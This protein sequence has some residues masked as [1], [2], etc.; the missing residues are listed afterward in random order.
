MDRLIDVLEQTPTIHTDPEVVE[1]Y[2]D[3]TAECR[4][5]GHA[6]QDK[7]HT[8]DRWIAACAVAKQFDLLSGDAIFEGVPNLTIRN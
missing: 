4:R 2:A 5:S 8:G 3:L 1:A 6:L 7:T